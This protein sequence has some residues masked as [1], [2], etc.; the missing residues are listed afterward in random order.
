M[1]SFVA[2]I[3]ERIGFIMTDLRAEYHSLMT[4]GLL[5]YKRRFAVN[6]NSS[7]VALY[8]KHK[9]CLSIH[10]G[11]QFKYIKRGIQV[12]GSKHFFLSWKHNEKSCFVMWG[13]SHSKIIITTK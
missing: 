5:I 1:S 7:T 9:G 11:K 13:F 6:V 10:K 8:F 2:A 3:D 4:T 12:N